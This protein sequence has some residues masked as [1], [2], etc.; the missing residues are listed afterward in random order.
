[1]PR[2]VPDLR[3][4]PGTNSG[5]TPAGVAAFDN[6]RPAAVVRE[7]IQ[8]ALDAARSA[9]VSPAIVRFRLT[10]IPRSKIPGIKSYKSAFAKAVKTQKEITSGSLA[11]QAQRT[12]EG[13]R[14]ALA[15]DELDV[16]SVLD[17]GVG[18]DE[19]R[20][21]ALLGDGISLKDVAATGTYGNGHSTAIPASN[22]RYILYGGLSKGGHRIGAGHA[23]LASHYIKGK[24]HH[25][26]GDGFYI[27]DFREDPKIPYD[28]VT[29]DQLPRLI[30]EALD[31]IETKT[32][33]GTAVII[34]AFNHFLEDEALWPM[35]SYAA[36]ANFFVAIEEGELEIRVEDDRWGPDESPRPDVLN[37]S[38][39]DDVLDTHRDKRR[40]KAFLNGRRAYEA[41]DVYR[42][43][44]PQ[45]VKTKSG[46]IEIRLRENTDGI[47]R[48]DLCRN[49]MWITDRI[50][51]ISQNVADQVPF[52]AVLSLTAEK[53]RDLHD[54]IRMAEGP[55][56]DAIAMKR[57]LDQRRRKC[58]SALRE[59]K[60]WLLNNTQAVKS[61]AYLSDDFL[62]LDFGDTDGKGGGKSGN[63]FWGS[64]VPIRRS[65]VR[66]RHVF[67]T[68]H[69]PDE[70]APP[71]AHKPGKGSGTSK[72]RRRPS[73]PAFFQAASCPA[74]ENRRRIL[75]ECKKS[76]TD[77]QLRLIVDEALDA[78]CARPGQ[79]PYTPAVLCNIT[80]NAEPPNENA[81]VRW[82][83]QVVGVRLGDLAE[84]ESVEVETDYR[85]LGDF[86]N[87]RNPSLRVEVF[88]TERSVEKGADGNGRTGQDGQEGE[89]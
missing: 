63:A 82:D 85:L 13:I 56:H 18:L 80:I 65:P 45:L 78:T 67:P 39:L 19:Q 62:T 26:S 75:I 79:D 43:G 27:K 49:G 88:R 34:P 61:D 36:S 21:T 77:A 89:S 53:G 20:M 15:Q 69:G 52:H 66:E 71:E 40:T 64:P 86:R 47:T 38:N 17:N 83:D 28:Y 32:T 44:E 37:R 16:L 12:A 58:R 31:F 54:F 60:E 30:T 4:G 14:N 5:F 72:E 51:G 76:C 48:I 10:R 23:V 41:H 24:R 70:H 2:R 55:L 84:G 81:L 29:N 1:M 42:A 87:L 25:Q 46:M 59:I 33:H 68:P 6:L 7:L 73:L 50:P 74:G 35:V 11:G 22:L 9:G 8:N 3:F 57:L